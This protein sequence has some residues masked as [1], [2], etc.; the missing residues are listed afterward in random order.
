MSSDSDVESTKENHL[1]DETTVRKS[2][3]DDVA[4]ARVRGTHDVPIDEP[5]WLPMGIGSDQHPAPVDHLAVAL[6][7]CQVEVL[8]QALQKARVEE[9]DIRARA[10]IDEL[11]TGNAPGGMP[12]NTSHIIEHIDIDLTVETTAEFE[13]S[14]R[15]CLEVYDDGCIVGQSY[16]AGIEYTPRTNVELRD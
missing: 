12:A 3:D 4:V 15:R 1:G 16:R 11:G 2:D 13:S 14:V 8:D 10:E 7:S 9:Y 6:V 5:E